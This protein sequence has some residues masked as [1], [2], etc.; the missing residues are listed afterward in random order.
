VLDG[1]AWMRFLD[2]TDPSRPFT[3]GAGAL[4]RDGAFRRHVDA[5]MSL[6]LGLVR[7]RFAELLE[8]PGRMRNDA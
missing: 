5:D 1:D 6:V 3:Q 4:L 2:G 7:T 8:Q